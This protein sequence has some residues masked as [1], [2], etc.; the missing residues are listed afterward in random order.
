MNSHALAVL[1]FHRALEQVAGRALSPLGRDRILE[2]RP[3]HHLKPIQIELQRV[4][5]M[6]LF[7]GRH[8]DW[9]APEIPDSRTGL[10]RLSLEGNV[11]E[12]LELFSMARLLTSGRELDE[13]LAR[14][15]EDLPGLAFLRDGLYKDR[16]LEK[17]ILKVVDGEGSVLDTASKDLGRIRANLR[18]AHARIVQALEKYLKTLPE[19]FIL[20]DASVSIRDG[21]YVIPI[22]R[23]GKGEVGGVV[24]DES[25]TGA[26]LFVEPPIA[27]QLMN[28]LRALERDEAREV[29]RILREQTDA[30]RPLLPLL[31]A[32]QE[33]L[34]VFDTLFARARAALSW[35]GRAP[36]LLP[37][38]VQEL[39]IVDGRHPLLL[40]RPGGE[41]EVVPFHLTLEPG[42]RAMVVSGPNTGGKS[43]FLKALGLITTL[44][45]SGVI[46]PIGKG[47]RLPFFT[48]VFADIGDEQSIAESLSTF[49][50][51][52]S[53][54][55]E[56]LLEADDGSLVLIDEMG[57]GTDP[58]EGAAL[59]RAVIEALVARGALT[60][61]TSHLGALKRLDAEGSGIVN[62]SLQFDPD[63]IEPTYQLQK[64]RPGRSYGLAIARRLGFPSDALDAAEAYLPKDEARMEEL[65]S[66]LERKEREASSLVDSLTSEKARADRLTRELEER[67]KELRD[68]ERSAEDR[69]REEARRL[70]LEARQEVEAAIQEVRVAAER[71]VEDPESLAEASRRARRRVEAA[72]RRHRTIPNDSGGGDSRRRF[73]PGDRVALAGS[74]AGGKVVELREDRV[75][76]E[77]AG[78]RLQV[79]A[80]DLRY[81]GPAQERDDGGRGA[82]DRTASSWQGP[83]AHPEPEVDLRGMR[84]AEVDPALDRAVDQAVLGGL[85]ELR[86][87][88]GKG[89]GALRERVAELL[90]QD[91]R[92][93]EFRMGLPGEGGAGVTVVKFK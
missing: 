12:P 61:A 16:G 77:T 14:A 70:L 40:A 58:Q 5:E 9:I 88:H 6:A 73:E 18:R 45:Q 11:L 92:V 24:L 48:N 86:V 8:R 79:S 26:T 36:L 32:S 1:E 65:L 35:E 13:G 4:E 3:G 47:T 55:K 23:E 42:E 87:I 30:L 37:P 66:T 78:V 68:R 76:V 17:A 21:R 63:R 75:V 10:K 71:E 29:H 25:A 15:R 50:A 38:G 31:A 44:A 46:P 33:A 84:V 67:A 85:G 2:L 57:T 41:G 91:R 90:A 7:L 72:A 43:V 52:L 83:E 28:D 60:V 81:K 82:A 54:L 20:A 51:H 53:N 74:G 80:Q 56:I 89:T 62:A 49:S 27:Q 19:R 22:R 34:V 59:S 39:T 93:S 64:G 69:A